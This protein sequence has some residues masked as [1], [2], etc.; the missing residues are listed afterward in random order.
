MAVL[1]RRRGRRGLALV[2]AALF[3]PLLIVL[4]FGLIEYGWM[5]LKAQ[6]IANASR[7]GARAGV[8]VGATNSEVSSAVTQ[9]MTAA[10]LDDSGYTLSTSPGDVSTAAAGSVVTVSV[11]V[12]YPNIALTNIPL[13]PVPENLTGSTSMVKEGT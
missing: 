5:F 10:N 2:E 7:N 4:L 13:I 3:L 11:V 1:G 6:Q 9:V 12:P 8:L